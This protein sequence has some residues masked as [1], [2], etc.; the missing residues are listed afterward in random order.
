MATWPHACAFLFARID[1][2]KVLFLVL[3]MQHRFVRLAIL[4]LTIQKLELTYQV[5]QLSTT[6]ILHPFRL[7][8]YQKNLKRKSL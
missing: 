7:F 5:N 8:F 1:V 3:Y 6:F 4:K 2:H